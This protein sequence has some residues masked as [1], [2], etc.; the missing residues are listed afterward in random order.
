MVHFPASHV[1]LPEGCWM[2]L[3]SQIHGAS[4]CWKIYLHLLNDPVLQVD[5]PYMKFLCGF[6]G[7]CYWIFSEFSWCPKGTYLE[8]PIFLGRFPGDLI[9]FKGVQWDFNSNHGIL[10]WEYVMGCA[11]FTVWLM[12]HGSFISQL[13]P[14]IMGQRY[15]KGMA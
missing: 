9:G 11:K 3:H 2:G 15:P 14:N 13:D 1:W 5:I 4:W 10:S 7:D 6:H 8:F 12:G